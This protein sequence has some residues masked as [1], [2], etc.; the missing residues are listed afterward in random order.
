MLTL[1]PYYNDRYLY[2]KVAYAGLL[3][4]I[5]SCLDIEHIL[6]GKLHYVMFYLGL[7]AYP[8]MAFTVDENLKNLPLQIRVG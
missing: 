4:F 6:L 8:R 1:Q 3:V 5:H 7:T 2:S